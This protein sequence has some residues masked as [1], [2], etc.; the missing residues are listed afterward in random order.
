MVMGEI[1]SSQND[2]ASQ[3]VTIEEKLIRKSLI[4]DRKFDLT[5][6]EMII[7]P[8]GRPINGEQFQVD[9]ST[10]NGT[11]TQQL[12]SQARFLMRMAVTRNIESDAKQEYHFSPKTSIFLDCPT[13]KPI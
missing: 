10:M 11:T 2:I 9:L 5:T 12:V 6:I 1:Y 7:R 13:Q 3:K 8:R 4:T